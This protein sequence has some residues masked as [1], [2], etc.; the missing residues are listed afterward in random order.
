MRRIFQFVFTPVL[1]I[2]LCLNLSGQK[3]ELMEILKE[4][5]NREFDELQGKEYP[6]YFIQFRVA[7]NY[8]VS[9]A[10]AHG[11]IT[12]INE[13]RTKTFAPEFRIGD[14]S[15]D[16]TH[17]LKNGFPGYFP[18][19]MDFGSLPLE[20]KPDAIKYRIWEIT[21][22][23]Y[24]GTI[25]Q[26]KDKLE[27]RDTADVD[28]CPDFST[29]IPEKYY[30]EPLN[31][32]QIQFDKEK[33]KKRL[34]NFTGAFKDM[35]GIFIAS[36]NITYSRAKIY[37]INT[38]GT[39]IIENYGLST[40]SLIVM[41]RS[42]DDELIPYGQSFYAFKPENLPTEEEIMTEIR[43]MKEVIGNLINA[44]KADPFTGPAILS[45]EAAGV[46]FHEIFGHRI[47]GH[48]FKEAFNSKT[49]KDKLESDV[50]DKSL[51]VV[52]DPTIK[53]FQGNDLVG[54]Y[55][56]DDQ[57]VK[58]QKVVNVKNGVLK[59]FLM[60]RKPIE[61]FVQSNGHGRCNTGLSPVA[62]QSNL[63]VSTNK[64]ES[65]ENLRKKLIKECKKQK[66]PYGYYFKTVTGGFTNTM[67]YMPDFF[68]IFPIEVYRIYVDGS[69]DELV[70]GVNLI[71]TPLIMF[72]E[73]LAA[74]DK[75]DVFSGLC[76]AE[77]GA[78]PVSTIAPSLLVRKIETQ[79][80][81]SMKSE[82]PILPD[83]ELEESK[84]Q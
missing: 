18:S 47:E 37:T 83:P 84:D 79:N 1:L 60:S 82:W 50:L 20:N 76:G 67:N 30:D 24:R 10:S 23:K 45:A 34:N 42:A 63:I 66:K 19:A 3:D 9:L 78:V 39:E 40:L 65:E 56:Y 41:S 13:S 15:F 61:G 69:E 62:R 57:G 5:L 68:N 28:K 11:C 31:P 58:A 25:E 2:F 77:S 48:R 21:N 26:Y 70:R 12:N 35:D 32:D 55:K 64:P 46:F 6:P 43:E 36:A 44:P 81:F 14:Y 22:E 38:E 17:T 59:N 71:G 4:E 74:G 75:P 16:N 80:Q 52:S 29:E 8:T 53:E 73:I 33:W 49:F 27:K 51:S 7:D 72:S 54:Y